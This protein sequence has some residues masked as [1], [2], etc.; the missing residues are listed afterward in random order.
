MLDNPILTILPIPIIPTILTPL[1][2]LQGPLSDPAITASGIIG[3]ILR[4]ARSVGAKDR[5]PVALAA[6]PLKNTASRKNK[7]S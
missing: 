4:V 1:C 7:S 3:D 6:S 2:S 5:G